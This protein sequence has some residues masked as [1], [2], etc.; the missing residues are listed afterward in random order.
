M[1]CHKT[2]YS[3]DVV[4]RVFDAMRGAKEELRLS[5]LIP[6]TATTDLFEK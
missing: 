6:I 5:S 4:Q 1:A 2:Q 3:D